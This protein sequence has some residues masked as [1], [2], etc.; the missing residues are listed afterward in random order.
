M[1]EYI[2]RT[3][4]YVQSQMHGLDLVEL[5]MVPVER[6]TEHYRSTIPDADL[7]Y[8]LE[9]LTGATHVARVVG[10]GMDGYYGED[11]VLMIGKDTISVLNDVGVSPDQVFTGLDAIKNYEKWVE[12]L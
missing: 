12:G 6:A 4:R 2:E 10:R 8:T 5:K 11:W 1:D 7:A 9:N 3:V